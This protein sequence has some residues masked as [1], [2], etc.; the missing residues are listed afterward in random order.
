VTPC[1]LDTPAPEWAIEHPDTLAVFQQFGIDYS[2]AGTSLGCACRER[3]LDGVVVLA[4]L[5][6]CVGDE[7]QP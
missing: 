1:D 3:G 4:K 2:C 7:E 6:R 5:L